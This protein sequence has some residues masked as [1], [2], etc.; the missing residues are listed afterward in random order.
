MMGS[1]PRPGTRVKSVAI[2]HEGNAALAHLAHQ[3]Q[4]RA[5]LRRFDE[6]H[7]GAC[8]RIEPRPV[9]RRRKT[10]HR[11]RV[12]AGDDVGFAVEARIHRSLDLADHLLRG[13]QRL[14][15][16]MAAT[17]GDGLVLELD[18]A[19]AGAFEDAHGALDVQRIAIAGVGVHD[20]R[21]LDA[22]A[23][24]GQRIGHLAHGHETDVGAPELG[25][26]DGGARQI[27]RLESRIG[28]DGGG[29][30]IEHPGSEHDSARGEPC[31][32]ALGPLGF[33]HV[34]V[35]ARGSGA[36]GMGSQ[37]LLLRSPARTSSMGKR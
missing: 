31:A 21:R 17:F 20:Q 27:E 29:E 13:D 3:R 12:G 6:E 7:V 11:H 2:G 26:G 33:C 25:I 37:R 28:G 18:S 9:G 5:V 24:M 35:S 34:M 16:Q 32:Q 19:G 10:L 22:L 4:L 15:R 30:G 36:L 1:P 8:L 23:D 14:V